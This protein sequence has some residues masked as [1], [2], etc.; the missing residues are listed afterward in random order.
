[1]HTAAVTRGKRVLP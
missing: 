1:M